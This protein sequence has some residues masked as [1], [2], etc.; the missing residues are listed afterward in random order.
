MVSGISGTGP[1]LFVKLLQAL[2]PDYFV[3]H[4]PTFI[5][6]GIKIGSVAGKQIALVAKINLFFLMTD[7]YATIFKQLALFISTPFTV[8][9]RKIIQ[10]LFE[11]GVFLKNRI[12]Q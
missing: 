7:A 12:P 5:K 9:R 4:N 8:F 10:H 11:F 2:F 6:A 3:D 1:G